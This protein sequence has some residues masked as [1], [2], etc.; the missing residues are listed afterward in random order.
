MLFRL[1]RVTIRNLTEAVSKA[2][3][4]SHVASRNS[5]VGGIWIPK[6]PQKG[7]LDASCGFF[8]HFMRMNSVL[9]CFRNSCMLWNPGWVS[10]P[11]RDGV[12]SP[13]LCCCRT[14]PPTLQCEGPKTLSDRALTIATLER[15]I[16]AV[17][18]GWFVSLDLVFGSLKQ[19]KKYKCKSYHVTSYHP[20]FMLCCLPF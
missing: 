6:T 2:L 9:V 10:N 8:Q 7:T 15:S 20:F 1:T 16:L 3:D 18:C 11:V 14:F 4:F 12:I 5:S 17:W 13:I 19:P